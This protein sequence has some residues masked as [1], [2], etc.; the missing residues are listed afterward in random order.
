MTT[1]L[2]DTDSRLANLI[3][4][5]TGLDQQQTAGWT[6]GPPVHCGLGCHIHG[7]QLIPVSD[8]V[9]LA[10]E[11]C[12]P[13]TAGVYPSVVL[14]SA[15]G[16]QLQQSGAPT[17]TN[18]TGEAPVFTDRG[19]NHIVVSRR[20][21]GR[22]GGDSVEF[23]NDTDVDDH[24]AVISWVSRQDWCNGDVFLFGTSYYAVVQPEVAVRQPPAL[25]GFFAYGTDTD[26]FS[27]ITMFG[28]APQVDFLTLWM[29]AN[30]TESQENLSVSPTTRA[31]LSHVL[32]SPLKKLWQP[33]VQKRIT[34]I[35]DAFKKKAP[36][37]KYRQMLASWLFDGKTRATHSIPDGP[38]GS[39]DRISVPFVVVNDV[40]SFN[41]HQ[42]G[43]YEIL[44]KAG[45]PTDR[46][47]L[48]LAP[49][50]YALPVYRWQVEALAFFD[51]IAH[52]AA[53]GYAEQPRVRYL[54]NGRGKDDY[55]GATS[56]PVPEATKLRYHLDTGGQDHAVH[57]LALSAPTTGSNS[58]AATPF[59]AVVP[60]GM[61]E[62]A[63][64]TLAFE[65]LISE[66][67]ELVGPVTASLAFSCNEIDSHVIARVS[68]VDAAGGL[69]TLSM[70]SIR[71]VYRHID[72][73]RSFDTEIVHD[74]DRADPLLPGRPVTLR[75]SLTPFPVILQPGEKLR[76][77]LGS[78]TD[79]L[80]ASLRQGYEHFDMMVP[81]YFSRNTIHYGERSYVE[82]DR[83]PV[84]GSVLAPSPVR[85]A[86]EALR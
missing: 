69:H 26:Y 6:P 45:T 64:P 11:I 46:Q 35:M 5:K 59:G 75:F 56:F 10:A 30:F 36:A 20:G 39:L 52:G 73:E 78:R 67:T 57:T 16:H 68:R 81:P 71:P 80:R 85:N 47:W 14:F 12:T 49:P 74:L 70:G 32:N 1:T 4:Y 29:G 76:L 13:K 86:A 41:L 62:V 77:D 19:Y 27:Q 22:S 63:N 17:G 48:I 60:P 72:E 54:A 31:A 33:Q 55:V 51:H 28:G 79:Q 61:D 58:W 23:F 50:E 37:L 15:Y 40:G 2:D 8:E 21:M 65:T 24:E 53:N 9:S 7:E 66:Q 43:A 83:V 25:R 34:N 38:R 44:E 42:F 18:E 82:F 3:S 84:R